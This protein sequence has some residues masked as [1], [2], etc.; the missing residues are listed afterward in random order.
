MLDIVTIGSATLDI[1]LKSDQFKID[2]KHPDGVLLCERYE[3]K[4][5]AQ[6]LVMTS[7]GGATNAAVSYAR[8]GFQV[9]PVIELGRDPA[10]EMILSELGKEDVTLSF[11]IQE[12]NEQTAVSVILLS[13]GGGSIVTYRGASRMLTMSDIPFDKLGM[14][15]RP[16]GWVHLTSVGG[17]MELVE[18]VFN[19]C[20]E[21]NRKLF[22]NPGAAEIQAFKGPTLSPP[23]GE[24]GIQGRTL[25]FFPDVLQLNRAEASELFGIN[26]TD[27]EVWKSEHC[28]PAEKRATSRERVVREVG[29]WQAKAGP[30][31]PET[32]LIITDG[33][34]GGRVCHR[35]TCSWYQGVKT[36][37]VDS[38]G[39]GDALGSGFIA[40]L[41]SGISL[42]E[43]IEWGKKQ[44]ASVVEK[45]GAKE[46]LMTREEI[47]G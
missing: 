7:G 40:G 14:S 22:W 9:A 21:K 26:F 28:L 13:G 2:R 36:K 19:W 33:E 39:A 42:E 35:G 24:A 12:P 11:V 41:I 6:E 4:I 44:A 37:M 32:I 45:I 47:E 38:T 31:S 15:L 3:E 46:G 27:D 17:D 23:A 16:G 20:K 10:A 8:K 43:A 34:R 25:S 1:F 29:E 30:A 18:K 5:E